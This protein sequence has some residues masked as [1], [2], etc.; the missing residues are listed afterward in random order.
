MRRKIVLANAQGIVRERLRALF[1]RYP[2]MDVVAEADT[3]R[4]AVRLS[5]EHKPEVV[6]I[7]ISMPALN[8]IAVTRQIKTQLPETRV[9]ML[10]MHAN[11][12][13]VAE[14]LR[15]GAA[16]FLLKQ[17]ADE[18]LVNAIISS[19][20]QLA[21]PVRLGARGGG[22]VGGP[23]SKPRASAHSISSKISRKTCS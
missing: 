12:R 9:I 2:D 22:K 13:F 3:G 1:E 5:L 6:L 14:A 17:C 19:G 18:E 23:L 10:S 4:R 15:A 21:R 7:D 16:G 8:G 11:R 20:R